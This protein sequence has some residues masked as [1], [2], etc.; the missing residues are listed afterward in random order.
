MK[1]LPKKRL[2]IFVLAINATLL[3][4]VP[5]TIKRE[6]QNKHTDKPVA[7]QN[8]THQ[9]NDQA[10][11]MKVAELKN[12]PGWVSDQ[13]TTDRTGFYGVGIGS[14]RDLLGSMRQAKHDAIKQLAQTIKLEMTTTGTD[15]SVINDF[16]DQLDWSNAQIV[17]QKVQPVNGLYQSYVLM[18][19]TY[20]DFARQ[21]KQSRLPKEDQH[22]IKEAYHRLLKKV[23]QE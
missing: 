15:R 20:Q 2:L 7:S 1:P 18:T 13:P 5:E 3:G 10:S 12:L 23:G 6:G 11:R 8:E 16:V 21:F 4:C 22:P 14:D 9:Q 19:F 17:K